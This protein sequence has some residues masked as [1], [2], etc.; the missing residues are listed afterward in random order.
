MYTIPQVTF[1]EEFSWHF[2]RSSVH[3][4]CTLNEGYGRIRR[5]EIYISE[6]A[7]M[8]AQRLT[9]A[10]KKD[11]L[12]NLAKRLWENEIRPIVIRQIKAAAWDS[13]GSLRITAVE[14]REQRRP[15]PD[16]KDRS[17]RSTGIN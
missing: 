9:A 13:D 6:E 12:V 8:D 7:L 10:P 5:I 17:S 16:F 11:E 2:D 14:L 15:A 3:R 4:S 1:G